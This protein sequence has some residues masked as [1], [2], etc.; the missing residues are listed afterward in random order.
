MRG[1]P[2]DVLTWIC[3]VL[4]GVKVERCDSYRQECNQLH[5]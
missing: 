5:S 3:E 4:K 1:G 2:E